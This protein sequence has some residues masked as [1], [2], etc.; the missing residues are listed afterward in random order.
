MFARRFFPLRFFPLAALLAIMPHSA[1][2]QEKPACK[3]DDIGT[4]RVAAVID[5]RSFRL[6]DGSEVL[7]AGLQ[8]PSNEAGSAARSALEGLISGQSVTLKAPQLRLD[9]YARILA[10]AFV[11]GSE[12]PV[13]YSLLMQG[14]ALVA[15]RMDYPACLA[16]LRDAEKKAR[17]AGS[18]FWTTGPQRAEDAAAILSQRGHFSVVEG[19]VLSVRDSGATTY[20]NFGRRWAQ[21]FA[22]TIRK[23]ETRAFA[24]AGLEPK[25]L[26]GRTIRVR[27]FVEER[28]GP[29]IEARRP[30]QI[31]L[32]ESN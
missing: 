19:K 4:G 18:G 24:A 17:A 21:S 2:A 15:P 26:E 12:T 22:V 13:Q 8:L 14:Y 20:L 10:Y 28:G 31:E 11:S 30:E 25:S 9:R 5:G 1:G 3:L 32:A 7:L 27:G 6:E 29:R 16:E 23:R